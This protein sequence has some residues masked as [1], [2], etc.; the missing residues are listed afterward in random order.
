MNLEDDVHSLMCTLFKDRLI[1]TTFWKLGFES[2]LGVVFESKLSRFPAQMTEAIELCAALAE[3]SS[4][5][6][7][8]VIHCLENLPIFAEFV[9]NVPTRELVHKS[10]GNQV[11][12]L[13]ATA[14]VYSWD[15]NKGLLDVRNSGHSCSHMLNLQ[16]DLYYIDHTTWSEKMCP[17]TDTH[18]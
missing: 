8:E 1:A 4:E 5:S 10:G 7:D 2:G 9:E 14:D 17:L 13:V 16:Y 18:S 15:P 6:A 11:K 3:A 12:T